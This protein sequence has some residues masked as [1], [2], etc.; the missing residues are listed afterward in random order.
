MNPAWIIIIFIATQWQN[1]IS[2]RF[3][4][5]KGPTK[6]QGRLKS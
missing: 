4:G 2:N 3:L 1:V 6:A 5:R